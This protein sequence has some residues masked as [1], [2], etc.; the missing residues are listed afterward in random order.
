MLNSRKSNALKEEEDWSYIDDYHRAWQAAECQNHIADSVNKNFAVHAVTGRTTIEVLPHDIH[1]S[2]IAKRILQDIQPDF[3]L[4]IGDD[5]MDED[6]FA[7]LN[8]QEQRA[9][10]TCIVGLRSTEAKYFLPNVQSVLHTL[11]SLLE[12]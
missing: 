2:A 12:D 10:I 4:S 3:V 1:K 8:K 9:M 5:R 7:F 11:E 6:M